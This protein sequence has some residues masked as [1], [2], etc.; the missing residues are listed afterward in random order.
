MKKSQKRKLPKFK[1]VFSLV[2]LVVLMLLMLKPS[3]AR[4]VYNGLKD[5]Y[6][7]SQSFYFNCDKL[8]TNGSVFQLDNW[9]GVTYFPVTYSLNSV[10]N[11]LVAAPED[12]D[13]EVVEFECSS[14]VYTVMTAFGNYA[15]GD[16]ITKAVYD[17][18]D[19]A[20]KE[21]CRAAAT[22]TLSKNSGTIDS[23]SHDD[24]FTVRITPNMS[25][26]QGDYVILSV[27]VRSTSPYTK[28]LSGI[29]R[30][31]VGVPG[32]SYEITDKSNQPYLDFKI[33][34]TL[35]YYHVVI[36]FGNY[37][38][39]DTLQVPTYNNLSSTDQAKCA[40]ALIRLSFD[41]NVIV[42]DVTSDFYEDAYS[43]TTR[44]ING[45]DY[46]NSITF[47]VDRASSISIRFYKAV[48]SNNYTYPY[49]N[50]TSIIN[51]EVLL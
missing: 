16:V 20:Y 28:E 33:T 1:L 17:A 8:S 13:Y 47:G 15:A 51:F 31:N 12:I 26:N 29:V 4:Y 6:Y 19:A 14:S 23:T 9:D 41:P 30:L 46:I 34:N 36:P 40:S 50:P 39:G 42:V 35:D 49:T 45:K 27:R 37:S 5:Y 7:E 32:I 44:T 3:F 48:A 18:L 25:L 11:D 38:Y 24:N 43:Y 2:V 22:C 21:N 10:K